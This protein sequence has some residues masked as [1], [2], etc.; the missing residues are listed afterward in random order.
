MG[1]IFEGNLRLEHTHKHCINNDIL[2]ALNTVS[3]ILYLMW[4]NLCVYLISRTLVTKIF[5]RMNLMNVPF[6]H[7]TQY[8]R[9]PFPLDN[10]YWTSPNNL[11]NHEITKIPVFFVFIVECEHSE[12]IYLLNTE[13]KLNV[14]KTFKRPVGRLLNVLAMNVQLTLCVYWIDDAPLK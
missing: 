3:S 9:N 14:C 6:K 10:F 4:I 2:F 1:P 7:T 8:F 11:R 5:T 13:H 12:N